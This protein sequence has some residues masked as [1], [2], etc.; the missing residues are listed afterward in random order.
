M[1]GQ[2]QL[3]LKGRVGQEDLG[4]PCK[5]CQKFNFEFASEN[6]KQRTGVV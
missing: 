1:A 3:G 5:S 6:F 2:G 4:G